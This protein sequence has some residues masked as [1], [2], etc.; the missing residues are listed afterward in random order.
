MGLNDLLPDVGRMPTVSFEPFPPPDL[1]F[2]IH[3]K[4]SVV[5]LHL[6]AGAFILGAPLVVE[7]TSPDALCPDL[8]SARQAVADRLGSLDVD[9]EGWVATYWVVRTPG[10]QGDHLRLD[11]R[12]PAK[13]LRLERKIPLKPGACASMAVA[14]AAVL[15]R[16]FADLVEKE[17]VIEDEA[18]EE[19]EEE[20][21][22]EEQPTT[23]TDQ[24][25]RSEQVADRGPSLLP[26]P[27]APAPE[28]RPESVD[29]RARRR[30]W[31]GSAFGIAATEESSDLR[32]EVGLLVRAELSGPFDLGLLATGSWLDRRE[33]GTILNEEVER[34]AYAQA[35]RTF[36]RYRYR[37]ES[38]QL[39]VG[40]EFFLG[41]EVTWARPATDRARG[42]ILPGLGVGAG[43]AISLNSFL[44][45]GLN[46]SVDWIWADL[47]SRFK[48][49]V[50][51]RGPD[52]VVVVE[53][54]ILHPRHMNSFLGVSLEIAPKR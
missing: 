3:K 41:H 50:E 42:R 21:E 12:D 32:P 2:S 40:P 26:P 20:T 5:L 39:G 54:E 16:F 27:V 35:F 49:R 53:R 19:E 43:V 33:I 47:V 18:G 36:G 28:A 1:R 51:I 22:A 4:D 17:G 52:G 15:E 44:A 24:S 14:I 38:W 13:T 31:I 46:G 11:L 9:A 8:G 25:T 23:T 7:T 6:A 34:G 29:D 37:G 30:W 45:L 48:Y 10:G